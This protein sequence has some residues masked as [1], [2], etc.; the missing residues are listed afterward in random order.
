MAFLTRR[1]IQLANCGAITALVVLLFAVGA[2]GLQQHIGNR[3]AVNRIDYTGQLRMLGQRVVQKTILIRDEDTSP[4]VHSQL[5]AASKRFEMIVSALKNGSTDLGL[6]PAGDS[7]TLAA[8]AWV[9]SRWRELSE[10]SQEAIPASANDAQAAQLMVRG[11]QLLQ[12]CQQLM[13]A[14]RRDLVAGQVNMFRT[15]L[16]CMAGLLLLGTSTL[17]LMRREQ[18]L[19]IAEEMARRSAELLATTQ[20]SEARL[21]TLMASSVDPLLT[22]DAQGIV[23]SASDS[24]ETVFG[25]PPQELIGQNIKVLMPEPYHSEHDG[26]LARR[27]EGGTL[28]LQWKSRE[29]PAVRRDGTVVQIALMIWQVDLPDQS[30]PLFMGTVRDITERKQTEAALIR[31]R[32]ALDASPDGVFLI[33][34]KQMR[35]VDMNETACASIGYS[36]DELFTMGPQ[37]IKPQMTKQELARRFDEIIASEEQMG[38]IE[39]VQ[40]CKD[41]ST[42]PVEV[43]LRA[44]ETDDGTILIASVRDISDRKRNEK[45]LESLHRQLVGAARKAGNA[46]VATSVLHNVGNVL[47]SVNVSAGLVRDK[48][49]GAGVSD[50]TKVVSSMEQHLDDLGTYLTQDE[51]GKHLPRFLIHL[52]GQMVANEETILEEVDLL[53]GNI[54]HIKTI[55]ATQ[56]SYASGISG[57]IEEVSLVELLEDAIHINRASMKRHSVTV[58]RQLDDVGPVL[59]DKQKLLQV[60]VNLISNA[61][62]ACIESGNEP[63]QLTVSLHRSG[64]DRVRIE[65]RDNGMGIAP[66]NLTRVFAHGFTTR[67]E[68]HGFG[69]HSAALAAKE[70]DGSLTA[71]SDGVGNGA[72]FTLELP[73]QEARVSLC[74]N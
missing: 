57:L 44:L 6:R 47:N 51:R 49:R 11:D 18:R 16:A 21:K 19:G 68:G 56:Q 61:K 42:F 54:D 5:A 45:E 58:V 1:R 10:Q 70:L 65:V 23:Q 35:F 73:Y 62:Y 72:T 40:R 14:E 37:D 32:S 12:A 41:G 71:D 31:F 69:L 26:Y 24:V 9:E 55:V 15:L 67:K 13:I 74:T 8:I 60:V 4:E 63:K 33:D 27:R 66:E 30:E 25:W 7:D 36:R 50:L 22:I 46:E 64:E 39:T 34:R 48:I 59:V 17:W 38:V 53:I 2:V 3:E 43:F 29:L 28:P 52:G 20:Q